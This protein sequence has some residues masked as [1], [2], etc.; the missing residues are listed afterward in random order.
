ML[1]EADNEY[2][3]FLSKLKN[4]IISSQQDAV[5]S[6]NREL[7]MFYWEIGNFILDKKK[8]Q[9]SE[10][11]IINNLS[12]DLKAAFPDMIGLSEKNI[13]YMCKFAEEYKDKK[14]IQEMAAQITWSHNLILMDKIS[15]LNK[16]I[17][18]INKIIENGWSKNVLLNKIELEYG[19]EAG[20]IAEDSVL[21]NNTNENDLNEND[22]ISSKNAEVEDITEEIVEDYTTGDSLESNNDINSKDILS[23]ARSELSVQILK[24]PYIL[25]LLNFSEKLNERDL[26]KQLIDDITK[27]FIELDKG[28]AFIGSKY[29]LPVVG[30]DYYVDILFYNLKLRCYIAVELKIGKFKPEYL[31]K[32]SFYLSLVDDSLK[33]KEDS[34][35]IGIILCKDDDKL[36]VQYAFKGTT[37][38][39]EDTEYMLTKNIP[40]EFKDILPTVKVLGDGIKNKLLKN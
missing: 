39:E 8:E 3:L 6:V 37:G 21:K 4:K 34:S 5:T 35:A 33:K 20:E 15:D 23:T 14:F 40:E 29:H 17:S 22:I 16:T 26:E 13:R 11:D 19:V 36:I 25:D 24:D 31:G 28:F 1:K 10:E 2:L 9:G 30:G 18:Y 7:L 32:L 27:F 38:L 12:N